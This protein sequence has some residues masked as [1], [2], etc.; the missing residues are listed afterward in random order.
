MRRA[1]RALAMGAVL[2]LGVGA[3]S[4]QLLDTS[5]GMMVDPATD[6]AD[7]SAIMSGQPGNFGME[8]T[9]AA[10]AQAQ[11]QAQQQQDSLDFMNSVSATNQPS[12][13]DSAP[14]VPPAP[15]WPV[16]ANPEISPN[17]GKVAAGTDVTIS[18]TDAGAILFYT[19]NGSTPTTSSPRYDGPFAVSADEK[20]QALAFDVSDMPSGVAAATFAVKN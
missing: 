10:V 14:Y 19:T 8:V 3:A 7:Y 11:A 15:A 17:G 5:T 12:D 13:D 18:D 2:M 4:A 6:P 16:T 9:T 20:V 1:M